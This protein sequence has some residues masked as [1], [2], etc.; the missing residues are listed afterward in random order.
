MDTFSISK[1]NSMSPAGSKL[2]YMALDFMAHTVVGSKDSDLIEKTLYEMWKL[3]HNRFSHE[4]AFEAHLN[5]KTVGMITCYPV[6][7]MN[8]LEWPTF[9]KLMKLRNLGLIGYSLTHLHNLFSIMSLKEGREGEYHIGTLATMPESRGHGV[10][11]KLIHFAEKQAKL[12]NCNKCSLTVKIHNKP[13]LNLY[14][15]SGFKIVGSIE[16]SPFLL[17][18]M[19]KELE[20]YK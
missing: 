15:K 10:A 6:T 1:G 5:N 18:R 20:P 7:I 17:Y 9:W 16:K 8:K 19:V 12:N 11:S 13:A 14:K 4:F 2:N 3:N